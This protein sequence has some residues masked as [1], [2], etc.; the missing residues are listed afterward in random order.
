MINNKC[1]YMANMNVLI[2]FEVLTLEILILQFDH[3]RSLIK[4]FQYP[5][6]LSNYVNSI[7]GTKP[8]ECL[9]PYFFFYNLYCNA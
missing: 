7:G 6:F 2:L 4:T 1:N 5:I 8:V 9:S 3:D